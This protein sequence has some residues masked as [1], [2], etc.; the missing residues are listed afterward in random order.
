MF[1]TISFPRYPYKRCDYF[2]QTRNL[3]RDTLN[4]CNQ[5]ISKTH[6]NILE[7]ACDVGSGGPYKQLLMMAMM[8]RT[9]KKVMIT[10]DGGAV[11]YL[12]SC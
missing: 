8:T 5:D 2:P 11:V 10:S 6:F 9:R 1:D 4:K 7:H 3:A 12:N